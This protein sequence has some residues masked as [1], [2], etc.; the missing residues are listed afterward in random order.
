ME[1]P[2]G[3]QAALRPSTKRRYAASPNWDSDESTEDESTEYGAGSTASGSEYEAGST[4]S[5]S[6]TLLL[7]LQQQVSPTVFFK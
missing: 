4:A 3:L 7:A 2:R 6:D 1:T 5:G